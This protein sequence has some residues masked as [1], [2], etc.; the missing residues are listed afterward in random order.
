MISFEDFRRAYATHEFASRMSELI[1]RDI[2]GL[3]TQEGV[4]PNAIFAAIKNV[5]LEA[6]PNGTRPARPFEREPL[7]GLWHKHY[8]APA[9][10]PGNVLGKNKPRSDIV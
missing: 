8:F 7:I 3:H 5:E 4:N 6:A 2:F 9:H 1:W 10:L